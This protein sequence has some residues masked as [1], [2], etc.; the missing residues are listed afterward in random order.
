MISFLS[1]ICA[2]SSI[3]TSFLDIL[4]VV[5]DHAKTSDGGDIYLTSH[6]MQ[7]A[8][9]LDIHNWYDKE[10]FSEKAERLAGTSAVY[11]VPTKAVNGA[12]MQLVVKNSRVG[13]DVPL[14]T[15]TL[16]QFVNAEFNSPWEEFSLVTE[17]RESGNG[18]AAACINTQKPLAIYV[19]PEKLQLW[20]TGRSRSKINKITRR[21]PGIDLDILRQ[22]KLVY[23]WIEGLD[24]V[25]AFEEIGISGD[26]LSRCLKPITARVIADMDRHGFVIADM[27]AA[28]IIIGEEDIAE[29]RKQAGAGGE[30]AELCNFL[31]DLVHQGRYSVIDYELLLRTP[32]HEA[33]VKTTR[34]HSYL[35]DQ[36]DRYVAAPLPPYLQTSEIMGVPYVHGKVESTGG[37]LWVVGRNPRLFD[38]FLPERWRKTPSRQLSSRHE[39]FY[40]LT[41]DNV[42]VVWKTSRVGELPGDEERERAAAICERGFNSPFEEFAIATYLN[43]RGVDCTYARA[44]YMVGSDKLES[45]ADWRRFSSHQKF[46][47]M[48]GLPILRDSRNYISIRGYY[49]G[50]DPW[51]ASAQEGTLFEPVDLLR[52]A[53][54]KIICA[55][56]AV[57]LLGIMQ[58]RLRNV[59]F[60]GRL[61]ELNDVLL[62]LSSDGALVLDREGVP[63]LR[64]CNFELLY[65]I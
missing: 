59:G 33:R 8:S 35:D 3:M 24:I 54:R 49:N 57:R 26:E 36:R 62:S 15:H 40:T 23:Q 44:I 48:D 27:K 52:A 12:A 45:V 7:H 55:A 30:P 63:E 11:R 5:Y 10:W 14:D 18:G 32:A 28:H 21:H 37:L 20:Q 13:E 2:Y 1:E 51:V 4:G 9:A 58:S 17:L 22:Y 34:R 6:G 50:P 47:A 60:D 31:S 53:E 42:H 64:I 56:E 65:R 43:E 29:L 25:Q 39:V 46:T 41:K 19:P 61:L 38:Y 16:E